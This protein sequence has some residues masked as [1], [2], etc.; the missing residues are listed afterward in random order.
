M[1]TVFKSFSIMKLNFNICRYVILFITIILIS[2]TWLI[3]NVTQLDDNYYRYSNISGLRTVKEYPIDRSYIHINIMKR[4]KED[5]DEYART[6]PNNSNDTIIYRL[7]KKSPFKFWRWY[8]YMYNWRYE[9]PYK[10]WDEIKKNRPVN[11]VRNK[12]YQAF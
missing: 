7:Y 6:F 9:M 4:H 10:D 2:N 11:F 3:K 12:R 1:R 5:W 8:E